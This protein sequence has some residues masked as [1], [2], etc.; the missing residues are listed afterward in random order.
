MQAVPAELARDIFVP[1]YTCM[2]KFQGE[3]HEKTLPL[4]FDYFFGDTERGEEVLEH[5]KVV[6]RI[7]K[8]VCVGDEFVPIYAEEQELLEEMMD[9]GK[10][11]H[12]SKGD[13]ISGE[14]RIY[15]GPL[16]DVEKCKRI[17]KVDR[18]QRF[19]LLEI[20]VHGE[21]KLVRVGL[22]IVKKV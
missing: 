1:K 14:F 5:L 18:H 21:K 12:K 17:R 10:V 9:E 2:R 11:I 3:W 20:G 8:P 16:V 4:F 7:A 22:E 6:S 19:G 15:E 13:I